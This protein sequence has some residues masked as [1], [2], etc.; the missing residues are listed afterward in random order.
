MRR[1]GLLLLALALPL[2]ADEVV[3]K[4]GR[5]LKTTGPYK[6]KGR[7]ALIKLQ[8]GTLLSVNLSEIDMEKTAEARMKAEAP[9]APPA[10]AEKPKVKTAADAVAKG[11]RKSTVSLTDK[12]VSHAIDSGTS[13][14]GK[15]EGGGS[16]EITGFNAQK[17]ANGYAISGS[18]FNGGKAELSGV[19]VVIEVIGA[20]NKTLN[21]LYGVLAKDT[22]AAG[23]K[24]AFQAQTAETGDV[25]FR[26]FARWKV[27]AAGTATDAQKAEEEKKPAAAATKVPE[28]PTPKVVMAPG[29]AA[30]VAN[31]PIGA[32]DKPG[33]PYL[34]VA[35]G[36][37]PK[38]LE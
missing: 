21:T 11:P 24:V 32:P 6:T 37:Q 10:A 26:Y 19:S 17:N 18:A 5:T 1:I 20:E 25:T 13:G 4:D 2:T 31:A 8:D 15:A 36:N 9:V 33:Q 28:A 35:T 12:D 3:L 30:P 34:P 23:E 29:M 27:P 38:P 16:I 22:V 14:D 7:Q